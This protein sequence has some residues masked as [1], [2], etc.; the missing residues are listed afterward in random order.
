MQL[1]KKFFSNFRYIYSPK[2]LGR[3][4]EHMKYPGITICSQGWIPNVMAKAI[5]K[6]TEEYIATKYNLDINT[7]RDI[8]K[9]NETLKLQYEEEKDKELYPG[10]TASVTSMASA[11]STNNNPV[12]GDVRFFILIE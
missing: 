2:Y 8:L 11:M 4:V 12:N 6:Q 3:P 7:V 9:N 1:I 5:V 10:A